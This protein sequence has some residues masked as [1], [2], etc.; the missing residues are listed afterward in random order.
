MIYSQFFV[1]AAW[2]SLRGEEGYRVGLFSPRVGT[3]VEWLGTAFS[4]GFR[5]RKVHQQ[6][7]ELWGL[8]TALR[9][10]CHLGWGGVTMFLDNAGAIYQ[11]VRGRASAGLW[12]QQWILRNV[13]L[14]L[15]RHPLVVHFVFVPT[16]LQPVDPI[17][18]LEVSCGG[19]IARAL[20]PTHGIFGGWGP[21][22]PLP[23][24]SGQ[25]PGMWVKRW[26][27]W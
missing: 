1:D 7:A 25:W 16:F 22:Y 21:I 15:F 11:G 5:A 9:L 8:W 19:C 20:E 17:S 26:G 27:L 4:L 23:C 10:A 13:N 24:L 2:D 6:I 14:L 18:G 3:Q 12:V